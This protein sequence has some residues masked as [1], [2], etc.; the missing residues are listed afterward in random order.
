MWTVGEE[1]NKNEACVPV[2]F[3]KFALEQHKERWEWMLFPIHY[4]SY[5]LSPH[6]HTTRTCLRS[7]RS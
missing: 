7:A 1:W 2:A 5:A 3:K 4:V 6:Y